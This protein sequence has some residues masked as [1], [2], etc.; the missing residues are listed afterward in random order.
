MQE[1]FENRESQATVTGNGD[2]NELTQK[3]RDHLKSIEEENDDSGDNV[4]PFIDPKT[5]H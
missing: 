2:V 1:M 5:L 3:L 4:L